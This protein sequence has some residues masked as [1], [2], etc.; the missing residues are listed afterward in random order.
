MK[1]SVVI[2]NHN[3]VKY[4]RECI[5][6]VLAQTLLPHEV[7]V[8]DDGSTDESVPMLQHHY[9]TNAL[10]KIIPQPHS[11]QTMAMAVAIENATGDIICILDSDDRYKPGYL[12]ELETHYTLR[13]H[14]DLTFCRFEAFGEEPFLL[15]E[16]VVWLR[17]SAD[18]D[19][20][21]TALLTYFKKIDWIGNFTSTLS[22]RIRMARMLNLREAATSFYANS[23]LD[24]VVLLGTS[25]FGGIK[26]YLHKELVEYRQH[27]QSHSQQWRNQKLAGYQRWL[28]DAQRQNYYRKRSGILEPMRW[29]MRGELATVPVLTEAHREHYKPSHPIAMPFRALRYLIRQS[30]PSSIS[31]L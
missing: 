22:L 8:V 25:L 29:N 10:V 17:P 5:D 23:Q 4:L 26:Y 21:A 28:Y 2:S 14:V 19:Y 12:Q 11:G 20:G 13:P 27:T 18:Y 31:H 9:G 15:N 6:S 7:I 1:F 24:Y 16:D 3:C 30:Y